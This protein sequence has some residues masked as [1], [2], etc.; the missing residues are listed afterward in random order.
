LLKVEESWL[1]RL[2]RLATLRA[3]T[4]GSV[5]SE[6]KEEHSGRDVLLPVVPRRDL[7]RLLPE[8]FPDLDDA[9][10]PWQHVSRKA[11]LRGTRKGT[12]VCLLLAGA[13]WVM[14]RNWEGLWP[15]LFVPAV[16]LV[17]FMNY[18]HLGYWLGER[19]FRTRSGWL[20]RAT[21]IVPVRNIQSVVIRQ[22]PFDRWLRV[23]TLMVDSAG[24]AHTG[25]GPRIRNVPAADAL[26]VART[27]AQRAACTRYRV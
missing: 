3:D 6:H 4:A 26:G 15:L 1:R 12:A 25:G 10:G 14:Q 2:F 27:L 23:A 8:F 13:F 21:H 16:Y 24:Q 20:N 19:F 18:R 11:I 7:D 17:N 9:S 5:G 22:T